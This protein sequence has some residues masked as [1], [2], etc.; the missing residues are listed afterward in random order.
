[1]RQFS[2]RSL[3]MVALVLLIPIA[4]FAQEAAISGTIT[5]TT[6][7]VLPGVVIRAVNAASGNSFEAVTDGSGTFRMPVR[8]G[9]YEI[10]AE[11]SGFSTVTRLGL[12]LLVGQTVAVKLQLSPSTVQETVTVT[13]EAPLIETTS[14]SMSANI[15]PRQMTELPINGRNWQDLLAVAPGARSQ[16]PAARRQR[17]GGRRH[18]PVERGRPAGDADVRRLGQRVRTAPLQPGCDCRGRV[19]VEPFRRDAGAVDG[20]PGQRDHQVGHEQSGRDVCRVLSRRLDERGG[21]CREHRAAVCEPAVVDH[22]RRA[23]RQGS[24]PLLFLREYEREPFSSFYN[25]PVPAFNLTSTETRTEK[26]A[27]LRL[28]GQFSTQTRLA[29]R[30]S[31]A[32]PYVPNEALNGSGIATPNGAITNDQQ[33]QQLQATL[34]RVLGNRAVNETRLGFNHYSWLRH[35]QTTFSPTPFLS[36][37]VPDYEQQFTPLMAPHDLT[38]NFMVN[39]QGLSNGG[40]GQPQTF[41]QEDHTLRNDFTTSFN[42]RGRHDIKSG[43]EVFGTHHWGYV[44]QNCVGTIDAQGGPMPSTAVMAAIF[45]DLY[46]V[47]TWNLNLIPTSLIRRFQQAIGPINEDLPRWDYALWL[48]EDW[49]VG[50][51]LTLNLGVRYDKAN[52]ANANDTGDPAVSSGGAAGRLQQLG[53]A[54]R[55]HLQPDA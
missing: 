12:E 36:R 17:R 5:D 21:P 2:F 31:L 7:G 42:A 15:D 55:I 29:V 18:V 53:A 35:T 20:G 23:D 45:P 13:G 8:V 38:V 16:L 9:V 11:L 26:K 14:S 50:S 27:L 54:V 37:L 40:S 19:R 43:G 25:T 32:R 33:S 3:A 24:P 46:D 10:T 28:D 48:Q 1:M 6:G 51:R 34:T 41:A 44:C 22:P 47:S 52:K 49:K 39:F 4:S 30:G